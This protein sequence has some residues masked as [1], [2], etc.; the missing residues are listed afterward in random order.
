MPEQKHTIK[1]QIRRRALWLYVAFFVVVVVIITRLIYIQYFSSSTAEYA[2]AISDRILTTQTLKA[3]RGDILMR[4]GEPLATVLPLYQVYFDFGSEA[5]DSV[6]RYNKLSDSLAGLLGGYFGKEGYPKSYFKQKFALYHSH[7]RFDDR[8]RRRYKSIELLPRWIDFQEWSKIKQ[9]TILNWDIGLTYTLEDS[10]TRIYPLGDIAKRTVG[11]HQSDRIKTAFGIEHVFDSILRGVDGQQS[12][13]RFAHRFTSNVATDGAKDDRPKIDGVDIVTT[14]D[15]RIQEISDV[16]LRKNMVANNAIWGTAIVMSVETGEI[17]ALSNLS[18]TSPGVYAEIDDNA[19]KRMCPGSTFKLA[20][21]LALVEDK[22]MDINIRIPI[23][24]GQVT[25]AVKDERLQIGPNPKAKGIRDDH[26]FCDTITMK[27]AMAHSSNIFFANAIYQAYKE[28]PE[29]YVAFLRKLHMDRP[30]GLTEFGE[31]RPLF[32]DYPIDKTRE[33]DSIRDVWFYNNRLCQMAYGYENEVT[34]IQTATLYNAVA[35]EGC[36]VAPKLIREIRQN[37]RTIQ[38]FDTKVLNDRICSSGSLSKVQECLEEV[39]LTGT[40]RAFFVRDTALFRVAAKTGTAQV[41]GRKGEY[42][43]SMVAYFPTDAPKYTVMVAVRNNASRGAYYG[44]GVSGPVVRDIIYSLYTMESGWRNPI[45]P[46]ATTKRP[47]QVKGGRTEQMRKVASELDMAFSTDERRG[48]SLAE[49]DDS[50]Q[51]AEFNQ[52][53]DDKGR[54]PRVVGMGLKDALYIL[55]SRGLRVGVTGHGR[56][57]S[58]SVA[59]GAAVKR[60]DYVQLVL[61]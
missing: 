61:K 7:K 27:T 57:T 34:A 10:L 12:R 48:W 29:Q 42:L 28:H 43:G 59:A 24:E 44:A 21:L 19:F 52:I 23:K 38:K 40:A 33:A 54:M 50:T 4:D 20:S 35:N 39:A 37:G 18:E 45:E 46:T 13:Q 16:A 11:K 14:L 47:T 9:F 58:Q 5:L 2:E 22:G 8:N 3:R 31:Q 55:E 26:A 60:G 6:E 30:L 25:K 51:R 56:V 49:V 17:L 15:R 1:R 41:V 36:M 32:N 53:K